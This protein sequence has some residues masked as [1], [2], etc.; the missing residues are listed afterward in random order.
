MMRRRVPSVKGKR[1]HAQCAGVGAGAGAGAD[2]GAGAGAGAGAD[3]G[4]CFGTNTGCNPSKIFSLARAGFCRMSIPATFSSVR[5]NCFT[6][7]G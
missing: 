7:E 5:S 2:F 4:R 3:F 6:A 1:G